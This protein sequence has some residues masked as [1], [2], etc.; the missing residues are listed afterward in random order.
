MK[1][2]IL[3]KKEIAN[4]SDKNKTFF[5]FKHFKKYLFFNFFLYPPKI[6]FTGQFSECNFTSQFVECIIWSSVKD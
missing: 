2:N 3:P 6:K 1:K 4:V 5:F